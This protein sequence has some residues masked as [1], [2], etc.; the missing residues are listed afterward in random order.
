MADFSMT[1]CLLSMSDPRETQAVKA[2]EV[3]APHREPR[4]IY[5][6]AK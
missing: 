1:T 5:A 2:A 6:L 4:D 3:A